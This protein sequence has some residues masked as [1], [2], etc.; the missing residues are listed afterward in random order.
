MFSD[1]NGIKLETS[2]RKIS[3]KS[4]NVYKLNKILLNNT[5]VKEEVSRENFKYFELNEKYNLWKFGGLWK[6]LNNLQKKNFSGNNKS[7][8][9]YIKK[10]T[11]SKATEYKVDTQTSVA[12]LYASSK[13]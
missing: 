9:I 12:F 2:N 10:S 8:Y 11:Y 1:Y 5:C 6:I 3:R 7:I 13:N 4:P